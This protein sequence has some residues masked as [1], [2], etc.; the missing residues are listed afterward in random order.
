MLL[1]KR[2]VNWKLMLENLLKYEQK[3]KKTIPVA[4]NDKVDE[5][6]DYI[7]DKLKINISTCSNQKAEIVIPEKTLQKALNEVQKAIVETKKAST[8]T[9]L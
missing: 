8:S 9:S 1:P 5:F 4:L 7:I 3:Q 2:K 6:I